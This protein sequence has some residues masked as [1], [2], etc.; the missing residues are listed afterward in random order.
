MIHIDTTR[1]LCT[2]VINT[3]F[4]YIYHLVQRLKSMKRF[5][6]NEAMD[7]IYSTI[8][9]ILYILSIVSSY[10]ILAL[11]WIFFC[12]YHLGLLVHADLHESLSDVKQMSLWTTDKKSKLV[13]VYNRNMKGFVMS[14]G[15]GW[16]NTTLYCH[17]YTSV[18]S[19]NTAT[20]FVGYCSS[21]N[22]CD[23]C[24]TAQTLLDFP[25]R[26]KLG[27]TVYRGR[28]GFVNQYYCGEAITS[29][30]QQKG[31]GP[32]GFQCDAC[33]G[34]SIKTPVN[35]NGYFMYEYW[36]HN[37]CNMV[38]YCGRQYGDERSQYA[39]KKCSQ[40]P[41]EQCADCKLYLNRH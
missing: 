41:G 2:I 28:N 25:R 15:K 31:C 29:T 22:Q 20:S 37:S 27:K 34:L 23:D 11:A 4:F 17:R 3:S 24:T 21:G 8:Q 6:V 38:Y 36:T 1:F 40:Q 5:I 33:D 39:V 14:Y 13:S 16:Y 12:F 19:S 10:M 9:P 32:M 35:R 30:N 26:N 7:S 18:T